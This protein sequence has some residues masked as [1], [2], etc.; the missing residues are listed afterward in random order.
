MP[1]FDA[2]RLA[3][4]TATGF[5]GPAYRNHAPGFDPVS[6]EG[7]RRL[8]GRFNPPHSFPV[9]YLCATTP[10]VVAELTHQATRQGLRV[11]ALLP[12]ELWTVSLSLD[13]VLDLGDPEVRHELRLEIGD[14][15]R[16]DQGFTRKIG[17]AAY[18]L[19]FQAIRSPSATDVDEVL[20]VFPENLGSAPL[21]PRLVRVWANVSELPTPSSYVGSPP[22]AGRRTAPPVLV[23]ASPHTRLE[24]PGRST[25]RMAAAQW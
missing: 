4:I 14:L 11:A 20:A 18:D 16:P 8:G 15:I 3:A 9:L 10:C 24:P 5:N 12:R 1:V 19:R 25:S 22:E 6:G 13:A 2:S 23:A 7:A 17:E 21:T